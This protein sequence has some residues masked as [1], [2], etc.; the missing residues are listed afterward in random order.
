M[1]FIQFV[2]IAQNIIMIRCFDDFFRDIL[3]WV[4]TVKAFHS[5]CFLYWGIFGYYHNIDNLI[6]FQIPLIKQYIVYSQINTCIYM[7]VMRKNEIKTFTG[8]YKHYNKHLNKYSVFIQF[9]KVHRYIFKKCISDL[10]NT[11]HLDN[12]NNKHL[13]HSMQLI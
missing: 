6:E 8:I 11:K 9:I 4:G 7:R 12:A 2:E 1:H 10:Q 13:S 3:R 5:L